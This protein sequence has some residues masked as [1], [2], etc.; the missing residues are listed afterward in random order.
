MISPIST[1]LLPKPQDWG[2]HIHM[3]YAERRK[4]EEG[5]EAEDV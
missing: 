1:A 5:K 2:E 4:R 3:P